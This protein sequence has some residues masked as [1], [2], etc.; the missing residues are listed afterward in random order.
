M[1]G[2]EK[3]PVCVWVA[4]RKTFDAG[5]PDDFLYGVF[6]SFC[7]RSRY[8]AVIYAYNQK[9]LSVFESAIAEAVRSSINPFAYLGT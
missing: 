4:E 7:K 3:G 1:V 8:T 6:A 2:A 9:I 5:M